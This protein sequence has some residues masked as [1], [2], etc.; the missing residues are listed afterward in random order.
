MRAYII[1]TPDN[2]GRTADLT[3]YPKAL[4]T[5]ELFFGVTPDSYEAPDWWPKLYSGKWANDIP[6]RVFC[7]GKSKE[8][9]L[10]EHKE[11]FPNEDAL[12]MEDD[13]IFTT[14][15]DEKYM[16]FMADVPY[17]WKILYLGGNHEF[18]CRGCPPMEVKPGILRVFNDLGT[19][20][21]V[22]KAD[23]LDTAI[24]Q[25]THSRHN[26]YGH[27]D[28]QLVPLQKRFG[29]YSPLGY[30]AGQQDGYSLLFEKERK[31]GFRNDFMYEDMD[32]KIH[33]YGN[34]EN[35]CENCKKECRRFNI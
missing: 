25:L 5:P 6:A 14:D 34:P 15:A 31:V 10:R 30:I 13:V 28:W 2:H 16:Q 4:P 17:D 7:C 26:V 8:L 24:E 20:A 19:E 21:L 9:L 29:C 11:K 3:N 18:S 32:R 22:F 27:C 33:L 12:I 35:N 23:F 1:T